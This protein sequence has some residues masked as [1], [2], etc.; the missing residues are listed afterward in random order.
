M[1]VYTPAIF[2]GGGGFHNVQQ[3]TIDLFIPIYSISYG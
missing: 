1:F 2:G 3:K